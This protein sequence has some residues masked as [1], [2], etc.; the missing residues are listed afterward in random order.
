MTS[1]NS[2]SSESAPRTPSSN[3]TQSPSL[4]SERTSIGSESNTYPP[5]MHAGKVGY[6]PNY[7]MGATLGDKIKGYEEEIKGRLT[8]N[9]KL[10]EHG[11]EVASGEVKRK[12]HEQ[13]LSDTGPFASHDK[14][15]KSAKEQASTV[16]PAGSKD[17][18]KEK[19]E[20]T[21]RVKQIG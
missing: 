7:Q 1:A 6:G 15:E 17:A 16:A 13:D 8:H 20:A 10:T 14:A 3:D 11:K 21:S 9:S 2:S 18:E 19:G 5:Q 4:D 12:E